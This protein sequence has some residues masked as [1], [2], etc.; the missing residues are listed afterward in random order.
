MGICGAERPRYPKNKTN[1]DKQKDINLSY[2]AESNGKKEREKEKGKG[3]K[4]QNG[5]K[6]GPNLKESSNSLQTFKSY[7]PPHPS[8]NKRKNENKRVIKVKPRDFSELDN[9]MKKKEIQDSFFNIK[10][11]IDLTFEGLK[12]REKKELTDEFN[13]IDQKFINDA[14]KGHLNLQ[15][16][17][18]KIQEIIEKE[19]SR[20]IYKNKIIKEIDKIKNDRN[21]NKINHLT[22][23]LV[24]RKKVG[25]TTLIK[26]M[27][28]LDD[29]D[30]KKIQDNHNDE[31]FVIYESNDFPYLKLIEFKGIGYDKNN[32]P[33]T[34]GRLTRDFIDRR[35][36]ENDYNDFI[37]CIWY[38]VNSTRFEDLE[39]DVLKKLKNAYQDNIMP[40]ILVYTQTVNKNTACKMEK[41]IKEE[42]SLDI[43][44]IKILA[45]KI[46]LAKN[47][48]FVEPFGD[49]ELLNLT[50]TKCT[51]ALNGKMSELMITR[52]SKD[53]NEELKKQNENFE[54]SIIKNN[55]NN[56]ISNYTLVKKD[57]DLLQYIIEILGRNLKLFYYNVDINNASLNILIDSK[58]FQD[59]KT[60]ISHYKEKTKKSIQSLIEKKSKIFIDYQASEE[61]NKKRSILIENKR[62]IKGFKKTNKIF[63]KKNFYY[64]SQKFLI[65]YIIRN[66]CPKYFNEYR[67]ILDNFIDELLILN[68]NEETKQLLNDCFSSKLEDFAKEINIT[69]DKPKNNNNIIE[70]DLPNQYQI[71]DEQLL[72]IYEKTDNS[73]DLN[74]KDES[75]NDEKKNDNKFQQDIEDNNWFPLSNNKLKYID[76]NLENSLNNYLRQIEIQDNY[77]NK[78]ST[79]FIFEHLK[80]FEKE[81]LTNFF[82]S[83]KQKFINK[84]DKECKKQKMNCNSIPIEQI[85]QNEDA[86][87]NYNKKIETEI[88]KLKEDQNFGTIDYISVIIVGKSGVGKSTLLNNILKLEGNAR[89]KTGVGKIQTDADHLYMNED[90]PFLRIIDSR[91]FE[92]DKKFSPDEIKK[93]TLSTIK[94]QNEVNNGKNY[95]DYVQCIWYCIS[96]NGVEPQ[97]INIIKGLI[98][99]QDVLPLIVVF[100]NSTNLEIIRNTKY[101]IKKRFPEIP[102]VETLA[103]KVEGILDSYGLDELIRETSKVCKNAIK[104]DVFKTIKNIISKNITE[105]FTQRNKNINKNVNRQIINKFISQKDLFKENI[106]MNYITDLMKIIFVGYLKNKENEERDLKTE[107]IDDLKNSNS[108]FNP[109]NKYI[110]FYKNNAKNFINPIKS[111]KA[112]YYL[113]EQAKNEIFQ[114]KENMNLENKNKK[115]GF[116]EII[117]TFLNNNF[118]FISQKYIIYHFIT[119]V[120]ESLSEKVEESFNKIVK[121]FLSKSEA[122]DL[123]KDLYIRK[124]DDLIKIINNY[125]KNGFLETKDK[126]K[127]NETKIN[128]EIEETTNNNNNINHGS[129]LGPAP[130]ILSSIKS[131]F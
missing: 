72:I 21:K 96:H 22:I 102:F 89:A 73:F 15:L 105:K 9:F 78:Q 67:S 129:Q 127:N 98:K 94:T 124:M 104:S 108:I 95:N 48:G 92:F 131:P 116:I 113:D 68:K 41:Y 125:L 118:Y 126:S 10:N 70:Y 31:N 117:E 62:D 103:E 130:Y 65:D 77:F 61:K 76:N 12:N 2:N 30:I 63:L 17:S 44:F 71:N 114:F 1:R 83:N 106:F 13:Q 97:D 7:N 19:G 26:Y 24:G 59:I 16:D 85:L 56:F 88:N 112:I 3:E 39:V 119:D 74:A 43:S 50:L 54:D 42:G 93:R 55:I 38:C 121:D 64:I 25:K 29:E 49:K 120:S 101:E 37:H 60:F 91:G 100:T 81:D 20:K 75:D 58:L 6:P 52:I 66:F 86:S 82:K 87:L 27:L 69:F 23:L 5:K 53:I 84:L 115:D 35:H 51:E 110:E 33:E 107:S 18:N 111:E 36:K 79:D 4:K 47:S 99:G 40:I 57:Y 8:K 109:I 90:V 122:D 28:R 128:K 80:Q 34:I 32:D 46:E 11:G 14:L 123:S 45:K